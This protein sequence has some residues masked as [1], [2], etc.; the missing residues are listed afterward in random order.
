MS[1][2]ALQA[3][4]R[5]SAR[6]HAVCEGEFFWGVF[7]YFTEAA[8]TYREIH[9]GV[10]AH[11]CPY[12]PLPSNA[13]MHSPLRIPTPASQPQVQQRR[14]MHS[15]RHY[16]SGSKSTLGAAATTMALVCDGVG[17]R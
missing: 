7:L 13:C 14:G 5:Q 12:P 15:A 17:A 11:S 3:M 9:D 4:A 16:C 1:D 10:C 2:L 8:R 6:S